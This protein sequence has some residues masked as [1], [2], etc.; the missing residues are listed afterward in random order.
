MPQLRFGRYVGVFRTSTGAGTPFSLTTSATV[1]PGLGLSADGTLAAG[2]TWTVLL[3]EMLTAAGQTGDF[4]GYIFIQTNFLLAHG[5]ATISDF[6]TYSL[7]APIHVLPPPA[8]F[9]R[10]LLGSESLNQ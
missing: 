3:S 4:V 8:Q 9:S 1:R 6:R 5:A 2:G 7:A 10:N